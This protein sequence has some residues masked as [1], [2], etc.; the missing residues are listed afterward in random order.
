MNCANFRTPPLAVLAGKLQSFGSLLDLD[1]QKAAAMA[2]SDEERRR[3]EKLEQELAA[4][5]PDLVRQ[6]QDGVSR[7]WAS[8]RTVYGV[9]TVFAGFGLV[10]AGIITRQ[11]L[12]GAAGFLL[13]VAA[14]HWFTRGFFH[15]EVNGQQPERRPD[16]GFWRWNF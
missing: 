4:T 10:I 8:P 12:I 15:A 14:G 6:L 1:E 3:L 13:M 9:L 16:G 5:D 11:S 7:E 2:L